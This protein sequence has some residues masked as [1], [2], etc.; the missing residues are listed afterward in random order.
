MCLS[1]APEHDTLAC[2]AQEILRYISLLLAMQPAPLERPD[3]AEDAG[4]AAGQVLRPFLINR[5]LAY[6]C[7]RDVREPLQGFTSLSITE[8]A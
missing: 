6:H 3:F 4:V 1:T 2:S 7:R 5:T 8:C